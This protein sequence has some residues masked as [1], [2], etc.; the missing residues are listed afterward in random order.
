MWMAS[1]VGIVCIDFCALYF[2][3]LFSSWNKWHAT[4]GF[5]VCARTLVWQLPDRLLWPCL[6]MGPSVYDIHKILAKFDL[7]SVFVHNTQD[8]GSGD[9]DSRFRHVQ[10]VWPSRGPTCT[11]Y[12]SMLKKIDESPVPVLLVPRNR[13]PLRLNPALG[14]N[15][16]E[17]HHYTWIAPDYNCKLKSLHQAVL[18]SACHCFCV[19]PL[20]C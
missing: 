17:M 10:H 18:L 3:V 11:S 14:D 5:T 2:A 9:N 1:K 20:A 7:P 12:S 16:T 13:A 6:L 15:S 4:K 19:T 8:L